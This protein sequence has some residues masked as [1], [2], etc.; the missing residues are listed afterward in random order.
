MGLLFPTSTWFSNNAVLAIVCLHLLVS[1]LD[2]CTFRIWKNVVRCWDFE[3]DA[4]SGN[5]YDTLALL[6]M[7]A[8]DSSNGCIYGFDI[9]KN[10]YVTHHCCSMTSSLSATGSLLFFIAL[11]SFFF[12]IPFCWGVYEAQLSV[13]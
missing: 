2:G 6:I 5:G 12:V 8:D 10:R 7:V 3:I 9:S 13:S 4:T 1:C 11:L